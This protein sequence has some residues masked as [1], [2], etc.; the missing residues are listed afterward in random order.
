MDLASLTPLPLVDASDVPSG[1]IDN[2]LVRV[3]GLDLND[4]EMLTS[5]LGNMGRFENLKLSSGAKA[6]LITSSSQGT[7]ETQN[8]YCVE[9]AAGFTQ[10]HHLIQFVGNI[11]I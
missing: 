5:A 9:D 2:C 11:W 6:V 7:G 8:L 4:T 3:F 1:Y 10:V